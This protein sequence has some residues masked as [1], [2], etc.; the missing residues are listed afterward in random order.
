MLHVH[1]AIANKIQKIMISSNAVFMVFLNGCILI[2]ALILLLNEGIFF[3]S[4]C[5]FLELF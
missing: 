3:K 1:I 4:G 2:K 5:L